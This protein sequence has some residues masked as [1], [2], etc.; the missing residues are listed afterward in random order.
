[1]NYDE[2]YH[3]GVKGMKWGHRKSRRLH[4]G[5]DNKGNLTITKEKTTRKNARKFAIRACI[6]AS[7]VAAGVYIS[8]HPQIVIK[9]MEV[10]NNNKG[11]AVEDI[12]TYGGVYS[13]SLGRMLT[14]AELEAIGF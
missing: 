8:K 9:G 14:D 12:T 3:H 5:I 7:G 10:F 11:K 4:V 1:M 13:K 6:A 2:L